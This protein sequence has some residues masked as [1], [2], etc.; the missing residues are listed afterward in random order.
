MKAV[1]RQFDYAA[2]CYR[3][4]DP[5]DEAL[6]NA[7]P[8]LLTALEISTMALEVVYANDQANIAA[9]CCIDRNR[10]AIAAAKGGAS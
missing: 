3:A 7:A 9:K 2:G 1:L 6:W 4:A 5:A 8:A 10:A